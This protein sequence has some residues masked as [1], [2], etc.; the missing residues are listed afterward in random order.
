MRV[1]GWRAGTHQ[2]GVGTPA[3]SAVRLVTT[4]SPWG[5][6]DA[7]VLA[8]TLLS[9]ETVAMREGVLHKPSASLVGHLPVGEK[10]SPVVPGDTGHSAAQRAAVVDMVAFF[11]YIL[12]PEGFVQRQRS[13]Q[14]A[15]SALTFVRAARASNPPLLR[16]CLTC[17]AGLVE[18]GCR[19]LASFEHR[20]GM[21]LV[22]FVINMR[23]GVFLCFPRRCVIPSRPE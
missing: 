16:T 14:Q 19:Q 8:D 12:K 6:A 23:G 21:R 13:P 22:N 18:G 5:M 11:L 17:G 1:E 7:L 2:L 3:R 15:P 9:R 10:T 4:V 20:V